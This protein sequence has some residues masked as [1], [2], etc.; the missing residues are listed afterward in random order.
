MGIMGITMA[1]F[2]ARV[3]NIKKTYLIPAILV[4]SIIGSYAI[5]FSFFDVGLALV[6]GVIGYFM[7]YYGYPLSPVMIALILGPIAEQ[8]FCR[9]LMISHGSFMIFFKSPIFDAFLVLAVA[10]LLFALYQRRK[11]AE[12]ER[13]NSLPAAQPE[14]EFGVQRVTSRA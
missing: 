9:A 5:Q 3:I 13:K 1:R 7:R 4:L 2:Y 6:F 8:N 14:S 12:S 10:S 11:I